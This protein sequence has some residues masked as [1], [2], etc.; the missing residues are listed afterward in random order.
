[1]PT[2]TG[3]YYTYWSHGPYLQAPVYAWY[4]IDTT[5]TLH[6]GTPLDYSDDQT[7][8]FTL[9]FTFKYY[10]VNY[11]QVSICSNGWVALGSTTS[12]DYSNS[13]IPN[14]D[15]PPAMVAG[16]WDDLY[17]GT[18]GGAACLY[19][20][21]DAA[22]HRY[23]VEW[24]RVP[25]I[26]YPATEENF[27][28]LLYDPAYY[29]T[30]TGDGEIIVQYK[31]AMKET[32]N[33]CGIENSAQTVGIQYFL[34]GAYH[35]LGVPITDTF[36]LK[37]TPIAPTVGVSEQTKLGDL[38][39]RRS[40]VVYPSVTRGR[41]QIAYNA[42]LSAEGVGLKVYDITG[43]LVRD[44]SSLVT[45]PSSLVTWKGDDDLGRKVASGVYF[46]K[47]TADGSETVEKAVLLR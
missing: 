30:P 3:Y 24:F 45:L 44:L 47:L 15:G 31:N 6:P 27:E 1:M 5:Q 26:S 2:D 9:P 21:S 34:E 32:D 20:Y 46:V 7:G 11:T 8:Q 35:A 23:V 12:T 17:P 42:G 38:L 37:Y 4:A 25:H 33:T 22:N 29:P 43:R 14:A 19:Y 18:S 36:A 39:I 28:I 16:V 10:G 41:L 40:L 13:G